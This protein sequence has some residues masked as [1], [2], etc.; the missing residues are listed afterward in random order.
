MTRQLSFLKA[1]VHLLAL[2][3]AGWLMWQGWLLYDYQDHEMSAN[4]IK[5]IHHFTGDWAVRFILVGLAITPL[6]KMNGWNKLI[7][8]RRMIGLYGFFYVV[9][10]LSNFIVLDYYFDWMTIL[11][12]I[13]KRPA[14]SFGMVAACL[15]L[16]LAIT[17]T[18]GWIRRLGKKWLILHQAVYLIAL[19]AVTHNM[20]MVKADLSEPM[21]HALILAG[22][23]GYRIYD[24]VRLGRKSYA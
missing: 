5:Y 7:K 12:E 4:P 9:L 19:L 15:L 14:I 2:L 16:L 10:H 6:R 18:K 22:L 20:M 24:K 8:F 13:I 17:S 21:I 3:P 11:K 23:L 1:V